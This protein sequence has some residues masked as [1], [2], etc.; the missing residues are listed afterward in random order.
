MRPYDTPRARRYRVPARALRTALALV[1]L[2]APPVA[3]QRPA[4]LPPAPVLVGSGRYDVVLLTHASAAALSDG[5]WSAEWFRACRVRLAVPAADSLA[6][7]RSQP[8]DWT[9]GAVIDPTTLTLLVSRTPRQAVDCAASEAATAIAYGRGYRV[10]ADTAYPYDATITEVNV[11]RG[12]TVVRAADVERVAATRVTLR[13]LI[14]V[15]AALLRVSLPIDSLAPDSLGRVDDLELEIVSPDS[16]LPHRIAIP[17]TTLRPV[18]EQLLRARAERRSADLAGAVTAPLATLTR[19]DAT[20]ADRLDAQVLVGDAFARAGDVNAARVVLGRA[21]EE[22]PCL[23]LAQTMDPATRSIVGSVLRPRDR[24]VA[25]LPLVLGRAALLPG[26]GQ[27]QGTERRLYAVAVLA[28]VAGTLSASQS[29]NDEAKRLYA[30]YLAVDD[31]APS[32]AAGEAARLYD[33]AESKR[34]TGRNLVIMGA[35]IWAASIVEAGLTEHRLGQRLARVR[36]HSTARRVSVHPFAAS[37]RVGLSLT[38]F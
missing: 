2:L 18:W 4:T 6:V 36:D 3:A 32:I 27:L 31:P 10:S 12:E 24:C 25:N 33:A 14:T 5:R 35:T 1:A 11:R 8:W 17:W 16:A 37:D 23:T 13:G 19:P 29:S 7:I 30:E 15:P 21:V 26:F 38:F 28:T 20:P 22:E 34:L 9:G